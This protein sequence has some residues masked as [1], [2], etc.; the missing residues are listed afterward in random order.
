MYYK[1]ASSNT[2]S[3]L[4]YNLLCNEQLSETTTLPHVAFKRWSS[5]DVILESWCS[6]T[7]W[8]AYIKRSP[9]KILSHFLARMLRREVRFFFWFGNF[10]RD[11]RSFD[12][13]HRCHTLATAI[14][15]A[16]IEAAEKLIRVE[17]IITTRDIQESL[18]IGTATMSI[19][20]D[21]L[22]VR[23]RCARW[24]PHSLTDAQ[25]QVRV[26]WCEFMLQ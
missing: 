21:H 8:R 9:L 24:I 14:A 12:E 19:L 10:R 15:V 23:K 26:E 1:M 18:S 2:L 6:M 25:R 16:N 11:R 17:P 5:Q 4:Y 7:T 3:F 20:H 13:E 22:R